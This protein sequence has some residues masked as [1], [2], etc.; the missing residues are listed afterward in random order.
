MDYTIR[1]YSE[2]VQQEILELPDTLAAR[3]VVMLHSLIKNTQR[4]PPRER[5][6]AAKRMK[7]VKHENA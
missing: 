6:L 2:A 3:Y 5:A 1:Y 4:T 7:A